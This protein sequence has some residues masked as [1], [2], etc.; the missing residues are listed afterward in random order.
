LQ[1]YDKGLKTK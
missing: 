1:Y